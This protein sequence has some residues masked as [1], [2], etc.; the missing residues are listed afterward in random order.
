MPLESV[1][2]SASTAKGVGLVSVDGTKSVVFMENRLNDAF[3]QTQ[4]SYGIEGY[5]PNG[6]IL[7]D[8]D[9]GLEISLEDAIVIADNAI[10]GIKMEEQFSFQCA[11]TMPSYAELYDG[12][13]EGITS[14]MDME[15]C[16]VLFYTRNVNGLNETYVD[17]NLVEQHAVQG[18]AYNYIWPPEAIRITVG[19]AGILRMDY[20]GPTAEVE[21]IKENAPILSFPEMIGTFEKQIVMGDFLLPEDEGRVE[22]IEVN[23]SKVIL[24]STRIL[25][26]REPGTYLLVPTWEFIGIV[27]KEYKEGEWD[28]TSN[29][30]TDRRFGYSLC[31]I[32][33]IDGTVINRA[34]GY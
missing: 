2:G 27:T 15:K 29:I 9:I 26:E 8:F 13:I 5:N 23:V 24:G 32:N 33:A 11:G 17:R 22:K 14:Y 21:I 1:E 28:D 19:D 7:E 16:Y 10:A 4:W 12:R 31:T 6:T 18:N 3:I 25:N 34:Q 30:Y 20:L